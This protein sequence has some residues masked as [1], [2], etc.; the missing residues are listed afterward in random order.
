MSFID[1][2]SEQVDGVGPD[3]AKEARLR[4]SW[5][6]SEHGHLV[7]SFWRRGSSA[8]IPLMETQDI[9]LDQRLRT[10]KQRMIRNSQK[11]INSMERCH[12]LMDEA[13]LTS[14][15]RH[16]SGAWDMDLN[17]DVWSVH[18]DGGEV[19][20]KLHLCNLLWICCT[21]ILYNKSTT[22]LKQPSM[23][24]TNPQQIEPSTTNPQRLDMSRRCGSVAELLVSITSLQQ[25]RNKFTTSSQHCSLLYNK[26]TP[27]QIAQVGFEY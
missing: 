12:L 9:S 25:I 10:W 22:S 19:Q 23:S 14:P 27:Q 21:T 3:V 1:E 26:F 15:R 20:L 2:R 4:C 18:S 6:R 16:V 5:Y 24:T 13:N 17:T 7:S 8:Q 11:G